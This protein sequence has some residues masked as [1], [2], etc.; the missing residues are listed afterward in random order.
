MVG[1]PLNAL[2]LYPPDSTILQV[3][4]RW[5]GQD[6]RVVSPRNRGTDTVP[7]SI[8]YSVDEQRLPVSVSRLVIDDGPQTENDSWR[9][10]TALGSGS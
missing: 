1:G 2:L 5:T 9:L 10:R 4:S 3:V 8:R 7:R 6:E